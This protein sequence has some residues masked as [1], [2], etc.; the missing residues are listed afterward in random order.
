MH[1]RARAQDLRGETA[2][3]RAVLKMGGTMGHSKCR[4]MV[5][6]LVKA[7]AETEEMTIVIDKEVSICRHRFCLQLLGWD[8]A[9]D[10]ALLQ[11]GREWT[12]DCAGPQAGRA[13]GPLALLRAASWEVVDARDKRSTEATRV[14]FLFSDIKLL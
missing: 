7:K 12:R 5:E 1:A 10:G 6:P 13:L 8:W 14:L 3:D 4:S 2:L 9:G 11:L